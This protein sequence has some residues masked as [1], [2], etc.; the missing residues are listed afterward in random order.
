MPG[1]TVSGL[2]SMLGSA[3][4]FAVLNDPVYFA[5]EVIEENLSNGNW[6][7]GMFAGKKVIP[8]VDSLPPKWQALFRELPWLFQTM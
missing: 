4:E 7:R 3:D 2:T 5:E 6:T 1:F 8:P